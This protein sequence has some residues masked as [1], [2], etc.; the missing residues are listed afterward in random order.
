MT[1]FLETIA[2]QGDILISKESTLPPDLLAVDKLD[3]EFY[4]S[5]KFIVAHSETGHHHIVADVPGVELF[6]AAND[7]MTLWLVVKTPEAF[8][9]HERTYHTHETIGLAE[10]VYKIRRQRE[11]DGDAEW[12]KA[13]D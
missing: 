6:K 3:E 13:I 9:E 4:D 8:I 10:G 7:D 12:R 2:A 11:Y 1:K 5:G